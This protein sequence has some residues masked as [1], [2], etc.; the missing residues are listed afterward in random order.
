MCDQ[1]ARA[2]VAE[3]IMVIELYAKMRGDRRE[4]VA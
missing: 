1:R 3:C 4:I 2:R